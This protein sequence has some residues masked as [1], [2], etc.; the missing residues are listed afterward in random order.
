[1]GSGEWGFFPTL[2]SPLPIPHSRLFRSVLQRG[3]EDGLGHELAVNVSLAAQLGESHLVFDHG[4]FQTQLIAG[5][6]RF[7]EFRLLYAGE[8]E[9]F[10]FAVGNLA[11]EQY[12]AGLRHRFDDADAGENGR[13]GKVPLKDFFI[14]CHVLDRDDPLEW[15]KIEHAINQQ[16]WVTVWDY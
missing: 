7:A 10:R 2:H 4:D 11:E 6:N 1:M 14:H 15:L 16:H 3:R 8:I 13:T 9:Q 5:P 12:R